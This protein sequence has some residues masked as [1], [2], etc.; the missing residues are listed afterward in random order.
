MTFLT[1]F[2]FSWVFFAYVYIFSAT[3]A[4]TATDSSIIGTSSYLSPLAKHVFL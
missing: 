3:P 4:E 2:L 1:K